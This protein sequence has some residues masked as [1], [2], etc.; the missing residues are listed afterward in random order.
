MNFLVALTISSL[1]LRSAA[2]CVPT[3]AINGRRFIGTIVRPGA[4]VCTA[5]KAAPIGFETPSSVV[6]SVLDLTV[7]TA[8]FSG[9]NTILELESP[10]FSLTATA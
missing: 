9:F 4:D 7:P 3:V 6:S 8:L 2:V 5:A 10:T 1:M